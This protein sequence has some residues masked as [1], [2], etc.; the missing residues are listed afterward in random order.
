GGWRL[1]AATI[2]VLSNLAAVA[3]DFF[4]LMLAQ[5]F[6]NP[7]LADLTT[8]LPLNIAT[9]LVFIALACWI[10]YRGM[11]TT[12]TVQYV[13][14]GF[15]LL[16]LAW[17]SISA[18]S[19]VANGT[20]FDATAISPD[21]FNPFAVGSFS[22]FAAG[23]SLSIFIYWGWDV[24]P[25]RAATITVLVIVIIYMTV[26][27]ATLSYAGVGDTGLGTGN[28]ENQGSIFAVLAGPVMGP[29]AILMSLAILSSSA[30]SLQSTFVSPART[31]LSMGHYRALPQKFGRI[32]PTYKSP[33]YATIASAI[34]AAAFYVIT[35]TTSE[36]ALWD[37]ITALGMMIC[38]YYGITALACVWFFRAEAFS[39]ARA[40][41]FKFLAPLL[42]GV[43]LLVMF[44]KTA[45]DSMDPAYGSGSS[46]GGVGLVFILG[47]GV[48]LLGVV[49]ML[50]MAKLRPEFFRGQVLTRGH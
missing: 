1:I 30:A 44:V 26:A 50:V 32:S 17:F 46:I 3:V 15:Q 31:L 10:S 9:T 7:E 28:P 18:F 43:I 16:V 38:F 33:S 12:K 25:G 22:A 6:G 29:F 13:L 40:F 35:R 8:N 19:H 37:T 49:L 5:I 27:L 14:V 21:W 45:Y 2:I 36:N 48:L 11:E 41:F 23:V 42:G 24:T 34:A 4:Y 20:A 39:G 47:M